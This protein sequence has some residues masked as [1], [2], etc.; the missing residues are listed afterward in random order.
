MRQHLMAA[1]NA[2]GEMPQRLEFAPVLPEGAEHAWSGFLA[3]HSTRGNNG[4]G[5]SPISYADIDAYQR[6]SGDRLLA[7]EIDAIRRADHAFFSVQSK[8]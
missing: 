2:T 6:V 8:K 7:W 1:W 3:L 4:F 5:P